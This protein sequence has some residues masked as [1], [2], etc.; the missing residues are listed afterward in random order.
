MDKKEIKKILD[1]ALILETEIETLVNQV[2]KIV[3]EIDE[4]KI[5]PCPFCGEVPMG[6]WPGD[7]KNW[8]IECERCEII[9]EC[10]GK[11]NLCDTW[12]SRYKE[13]K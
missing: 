7:D 9:M 2:L 12:N 8:W 3:D 11:T 13:E 10:V 6:P 1:I 5:L 4:V